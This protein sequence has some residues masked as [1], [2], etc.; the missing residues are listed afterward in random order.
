MASGRTHDLV[1]LVAFPPIVYYLQPTEFVSFTAGYMVGTFLLSPDNDIYHSTPNKRW[2]FLRFIWIPYTKVFP[3]RGISHIPFYGLITKILYLT[4]LFFLFLFIVDFI[5]R[6][7]FGKGVLEENVS[8]AQISELVKQPVFLS[9]LVGLF[10][11]EIMHIFTDMVYS[12]L[13]PKKRKRRR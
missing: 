3:H 4:I 11:S 10:L 1:N 8:K 13:K 6:Q 7:S 12:I 5:L 9:F 2:K